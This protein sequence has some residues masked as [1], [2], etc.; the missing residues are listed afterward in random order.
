MC[1][2][3]QYSAAMYITKNTGTGNGMRGTRGTGGMFYS[4]EYRQTFREMSPD[5]PGN[6]AKYCGGCH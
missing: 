6:V 1:Y 4:G 2:V 3:K 5:I